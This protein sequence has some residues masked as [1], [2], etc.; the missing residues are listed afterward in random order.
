MALYQNGSELTHLVDSRFDQ[1]YSP[2]TRAPFSGIFMC[3][4]CRDE[5][6]CNANDPL[7][8]QNHRQHAQ[9]KGAIRWKPLVQ[10]QK[11]PD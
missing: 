10:T 9:D 7:P 4:N 2:G 6:A 11:G 1:V 3:T 8:P 5:Y